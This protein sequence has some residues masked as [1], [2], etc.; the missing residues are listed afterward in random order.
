[1]I[2]LDNQMV[3]VLPVLSPREPLARVGPF[4][5]QNGELF[6]E[7]HFVNGLQRLGYTARFK[8]QIEYVVQEGADGHYMTEEKTGVWEGFGHGKITLRLHDKNGSILYEV[9]RIGYCEGPGYSCSY[10]HGPW[11]KYG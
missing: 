6:H 2:T 3:T 5:F 1:V 4:C 10:S 7:G 11:F 9:S 8:N